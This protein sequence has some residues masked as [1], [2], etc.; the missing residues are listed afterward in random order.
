MTILFGPMTSMTA[1]SALIT[2]VTPCFLTGAHM[3]ALLIRRRVTMEG[4]VIPLE[5]ENIDLGCANNRLL[6]R[7][8]VIIQHRI[9][10]N[11]PLWTLSKD[12]L[13]TENFEIF[14]ILEGRDSFES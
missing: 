2:T 12:D 13:E 1:F 11:S 3:D 14:V 5:T 9:N 10:E 4:E 6:L 8:P 7:W